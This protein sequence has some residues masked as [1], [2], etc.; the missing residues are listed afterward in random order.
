MEEGKDE[1]V[2]IGVISLPV[3]YLDFNGR[4]EN[5]PDYRSSTRDV[6]RLIGELKEQGVT[7]IVI[8]LRDNGGGSLLEATTLTGLFI[9]KGPVVQVRNSSGRI[10]LE[11]VRAFDAQGCAGVDLLAYRAT[12]APPVE[13]VRAARRGTSGYLVVAGS[14]GSV[15]QIDE[16]RAAGAD[17]FTIGSAVF[18]GSFSPRKGALVNQLRDVLAACAP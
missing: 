3:F 18:D 1:P 2:K 15:A 17:A 11:D 6:R 7:G 14:V 13:L 5:R 10:S 12:D 16:L 4:A 9:D 8:D